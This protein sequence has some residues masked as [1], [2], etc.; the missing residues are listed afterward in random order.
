MQIIQFLGLLLIENI[1]IPSFMGQRFVFKQLKHVAARAACQYFA[2]FLQIENRGQLSLLVPGQLIVWRDNPVVFQDERV[3]PFRSGQ[4][5]MEMDRCMSKRRDFLH[6]NHPDVLCTLCGKGPYFMILPDALLQ[7]FCHRNFNKS[8]PA[9]GGGIPYGVHLILIIGYNT[10][11]SFMP[12]PSTD[13]LGVRI[14]NRAVLV[15]LTDR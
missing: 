11:L 6:P 1:N 10:M 8:A 12:H 7:S 15:H 13:L 2:L 4:S 9:P 5:A 3:L 14:F